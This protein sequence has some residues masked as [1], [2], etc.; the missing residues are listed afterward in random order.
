MKKPNL[1]IAIFLAI[2][3]SACINQEKDK[4]T[5]IN[6]YQKEGYHN[7]KVSEK[8]N[9]YYNVSVTDETGKVHEGRIKAK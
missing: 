1:I 5:I 3:L 8:K 9:G 4:S 2:V 6:Y 7:I